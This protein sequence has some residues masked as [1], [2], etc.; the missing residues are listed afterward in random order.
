MCRNTPSSGI[1]Y[2]SRQINEH[3]NV[4][5]CVLFTQTLPVHID[6]GTNTASI[7]QDP[8]YLGIKRGRERGPSYDAL[9]AEFFQ[10][11]QEV[12]GRNVLIQV[13]TTTSFVNALFLSFDALLSVSSSY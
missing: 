5:F 11:A 7:I 4:I 6:V 3:M 9:I 12:Y 2:E 10:A 8:F 1:T 13:F